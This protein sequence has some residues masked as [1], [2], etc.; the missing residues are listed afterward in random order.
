MTGLL[1]LLTATGLAQ[2]VFNFDSDPVGNPPAGTGA[3]TFTPSGDTSVQD[4]STMG[5]SA[6]SG[7][8]YLLFTTLDSASP[9]FAN[10]GNGAAFA[11]T[12][13][14]SVY[15]AQANLL[16]SALNLVTVST[17]QINLTL[18]AG[19]TVSLSARMLTSEPTDPALLPNNDAAFFVAGANGGTP[20]L[21]TIGSVL[22]SSFSS[23]P[24][25]VPVFDSMTAAAT[26]LYTAPETGSYVLLLGVGDAA[27]AGVQS[28]L[29]VDNLTITP[30][31]E[32]STVAL[33]GGL[34]ALL[35]AGLVRR[36][37]R[38]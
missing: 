27:A 8:Q 18:N 3:V 2:T 31:P 7:S 15:G 22:G 17:L 37:R 35:A 34:A 23:A 24:I 4:V 16:S 32:P 13:W 12:V 25:S 26:F 29:L 30:V 1:C 21:Q 19:D 10:A 38:T 5:I 36:R 28:G 14:T 11:S 6:P 9:P 20:T 33:L